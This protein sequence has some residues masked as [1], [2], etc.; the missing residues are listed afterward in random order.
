[1]KFKVGDHVRYKPGYGTYGYE[2]VL[3]ADG[4]IPGVV[5]GTSLRGF[6]VRLVL[7]KRNGVTLTRSVGAGSL[8]AA[9]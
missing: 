7:T 1:M 2:D 8:Q 6:K 3:E 5:I 9:S 4:R